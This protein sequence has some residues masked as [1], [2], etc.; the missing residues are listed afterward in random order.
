M[1]Y[2][3]SFAYSNIISVDVLAP[4]QFFLEQNYPNPFN[5]S[6]TIG[7]SLAVDSKVTLKIYNA[8]GQEVSM[9]A[10]ENLNEGF[11]EKIF[12]TSSLN[13]GVYF[14]RID[15]TGIDGQTFSQVRKM[16]LTK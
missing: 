2:D 13:S 6:T 10:N 7:F 11:H 1:D 16:I 8:L 4:S 14:Y 3:G 9:L 5:P 15:V 12:N